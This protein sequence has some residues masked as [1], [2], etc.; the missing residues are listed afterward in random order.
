[1]LLSLMTF[2][3]G[4][5]INPDTIYNPNVA[6]V[7]LFR[8]GN[9]ISDPIIELNSSETLELSFDLLGTKNPFLNYTLIHCNA[10]WTPSDY[11]TIEYFESF[12]DEPINDVSYSVNTLKPYTHYR[13]TFPNQN[14]KLTKS[15]NYILNVYENNASEPY[16][17]RKIYVSENKLSVDAYFSK[18]TKIEDIMSRQEMNLNIRKMGYPINAMHRF[19]LVIKQNGRNDNMIINPKYISVN[20]DQIVYENSGNIVF[21]GASE[22]RAFDIKSLKYKLDNVER[23]QTANND[24]VVWLYESKNR[25]YGAYESN[26]DINGKFVIKTEDRGDQLQAEYAFVNFFLKSSSPIFDGDLYIY[27]Q[28][29]DWKIMPYA[30]MNYMKEMGGYSATL[31]LKQGYYNYQYLFVSSDKKKIDVSKVEGNHW[32]TSNDYTIFVYYRE[33]GA[34]AD[35]L[36]AVKQLNSLQ[37]K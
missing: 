8:T 30:K 12:T 9:P 5:A 1:M 15:G 26:P 21:D 16:L 31:L 24:I 17:T 6:S 10:D 22:F 28:L 25:Q 20:T 4:L 33:D 13:L 29:T 32:E 23:I 14:I 35:K 19:H 11:S 36:I 2:A 34:I 27:G 7:T 3:S 18:A 37:K